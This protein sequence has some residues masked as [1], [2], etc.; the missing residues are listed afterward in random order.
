MYRAFRYALSSPPHAGDEGGIVGTPHTLP[1]GSCP[2]EPCSVRLAKKPALVA[3]FATRRWYAIAH[4]GYV[5]YAVDWNPGVSVQVRAQVA[6]GYG[7]RGL[8]R[9]SR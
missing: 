7:L 2:L 3:G 4:R 9:E 1:R 5:E 8:A 6:R